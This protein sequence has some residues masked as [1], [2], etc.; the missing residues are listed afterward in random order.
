MLGVPAGPRLCAGCCGGC[1][2]PGAA[3]PGALGACK[4]LCT[5]PGQLGARPTAPLPPGARGWRHRAG[6][7]SQRAE[8]VLFLPFDSPASIAGTEGG[9]GCPVPQ[10]GSGSA[11]C[12]GALGLPCGSSQA[13]CTGAFVLEGDLNYR[14]RDLIPVELSI[15]GTAGSHSRGPPALPHPLSLSRPPPLPAALGVTHHTEPGVPRPGAPTVSLPR[16]Q[17][18]VGPLEPLEPLLQDLR[19][20]LAAPL[21]H[22]R[23]HR[24][25]GLPLRGHGR[26]G[27]DLQRE[28]VPR[29]GAAPGA[30]PR[31]P[32]RA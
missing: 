10:G 24:R 26:G 9:G 16:S 23:G 1:R 2:C 20:G 13:C 32:C 29:Y 31:C 30:R 7:V 8:P 15:H 22:V 14:S 4:L 12:Q 19:H 27:E 5:Y 21:P 18:Q 25:A 11:T 3:G 17:Q 28:E 6:G